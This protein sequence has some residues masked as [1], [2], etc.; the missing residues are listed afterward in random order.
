VN[1]GVPGARGFK[2]IERVDGTTERLPSKC[3]RI[4][5]Q[6]GDLLHFCTWGGGGWGDPLQRPAERVAEDADGGL[7]S[8]EGGRR[9]GVVLNPDFTVDEDATRALRDQMATERGNV[10]PLFDKGGTIEEL[11]ARCKE[12]TG[13]DPPAPPTFEDW[14][15]A[16]PK[17]AQ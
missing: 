2:I 11:L 9:Y 12:E 3:D 17:T 15:L 7:V 5:V 1:G 10:I 16:E 13:L 4:K 6:P 14:A 8:I